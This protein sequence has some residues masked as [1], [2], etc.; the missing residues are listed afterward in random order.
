M[1]R[2]VS[3][4]LEYFP[5]NVNIDEEFELIEAEYGLQGFAVIIKLYQWIY[6]RNYYCKW[7]KEVALLFAHKKC[8]VG[9]NVVS[10]IIAAAIA[11]GIFNEK[12]YKKYQ[13]LTSRGI[14]RRYFEAVA[15][16]QQI[17]VINEYLLVSA[18]VFSENVSKN[19]V[20]VDI[21]G[22][23][24]SNY[25]QTKQKKIKENKSKENN[26]EKELCCV[27]DEYKNKIGNLSNANKSKLQELCERYTPDAV[28]QAIN[29]AAG[30]GRSVN[31]LNG[32]LSNWKKSGD[33]RLMNQS[34][35]RNYDID[36]LEE[37][38]RFNPIE[39]T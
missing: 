3:E 27:F 33:V 15:R 23:N 37:M 4:G 35:A 12:L 24:V 29:A 22:V 13:I 6:A 39:D 14:Q 2:P 31:Y 26:S 36:E 7:T 25:K 38:N 18:D 11:R 30:K 5:L 28:M 34:G 17:N 20:H 16:R 19:W 8:C 10:E 9:G 21:N 1:A 32:I